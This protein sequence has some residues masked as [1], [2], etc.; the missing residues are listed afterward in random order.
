[1]SASEKEQNNT[2]GKMCLPRRPCLNTKTFCAPIA[3][4]SEKPSV[5]PEKNPIVNEAVYRNRRFFL[6]NSAIDLTP[7]KRMSRSISCFISVNALSTPACPAAAKAY[8]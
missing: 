7:I 8:K 2:T 4:I 1:M 3:M 5:S 6:D